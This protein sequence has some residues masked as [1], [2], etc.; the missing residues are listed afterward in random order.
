MTAI[1]STYFI[2]S[3]VCAVA[4]LVAVPLSSLFQPKDR[5]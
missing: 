5:R 3:A 2:I 4:A 1:M